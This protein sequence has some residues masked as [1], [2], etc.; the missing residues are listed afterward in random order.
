[1]T[2]WHDDRHPTAR[3]VEL[4]LQA[5]GLTVV[6]FMGLVLFLCTGQP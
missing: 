3:R 6:L 4:F 2:G 5:L 1:M